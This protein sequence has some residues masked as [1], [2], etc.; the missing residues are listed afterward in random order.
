MQIFKNFS[1]LFEGSFCFLKLLMPKKASKTLQ[2]K[3]YSTKIM[4]LRFKLSLLTFLNLDEKSKISNRF[5]STLGK[6]H[7]NRD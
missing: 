7:S 2:R 6:C 3:S 5:F 1:I 4:L